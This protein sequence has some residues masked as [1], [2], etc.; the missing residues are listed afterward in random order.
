MLTR[1]NICACHWFRRNSITHSFRTFFLS[2]LYLNHTHALELSWVEMPIFHFDLVST[3]WIFATSI[4]FFLKSMQALV[5]GFYSVDENNAVKNRS[6]NRSHWLKFNVLLYSLNELTMTYKRW[7]I[8]PELPSQS[9]NST[10][11][12][13]HWASLSLCSDW[14]IYNTF[15]VRSAEAN[16]YKN[17]VH[18]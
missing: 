9:M 3:N 12:R 6:P 2:I 13:V 1:R 5:L 4:E 15:L 8:L 18:I 11:S 17:I 14:N 7:L 16:E 10:E